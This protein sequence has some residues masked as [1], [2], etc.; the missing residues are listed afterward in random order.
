YHL[1]NR[2]WKMNEMSNK[3]ASQTR[4]KQLRDDPLAASRAVRFQSGAVRMERYNQNIAQVRN[5][6][7]YTEG[8]VREATD[9]LQR[10]NEIAVQGANGVWDKSQ[11]SYMAQEVDQLLNELVQIGN[12]KSEVGDA[13]FSGFKLQ[14]D[15][16]R[17]SMGR[18]PGAAG[19]LVTSVDYIGD[20][21]QNLVEISE[22]AV[23]PLNIPGNHV[24]W[25]ENQQIYS[26]LEA[27]QYRVQ[28]DSAIR[29]DGAEIRL[30]AGDNIYAIISKIND[31]PAPVRAKLD[32]V[33]NSLVMETALPHQIWPQDVG[34]GQVLQDLGIVS[35]VDRYPP[36][37]RAETAR[38]YGGSIFDVVM[39]VRDRLLDGDYEAIGGAALRGLQE[40]VHNMS[41]VLAEIGAQDTR[42]NITAERL[43]FEIP[44]VQRMNSEEVDI[45]VADAITDLKMLE[46]AHKVA[47]STTARIVKPT[48][49]DFLR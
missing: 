36:F 30:N 47:L 41:S 19:E 14:S 31:S 10:V 8:Y 42:L 37:N 7:A 15:A 24:F 43:N 20:I 35:R 28:K 44:E 11:L 16:F 33:N 40:A 48:L 29:I 21:G 5:H 18:V 34:D 23:S 22:D 6:L 13:L 1:R 26:T 49:L 32:P 38:V 45:D 3:L 27:S 12:A 39:Y 25:A 46:Y 9:I 2:E 4:I 17:V